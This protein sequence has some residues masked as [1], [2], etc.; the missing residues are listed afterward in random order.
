M[1]Y[2]KAPSRP[3][4]HIP[5]PLHPDPRVWHHRPSITSTSPPA[6]SAH[7]LP[8][9]SSHPSAK[10]A[11]LAA[12]AY[13]ARL[14]ALPIRALL[15][16]LPLQIPHLGPSLHFGVGPTNPDLL[17]TGHALLAPRPVLPLPRR[18]RQILGLCERDDHDDLFSSRDGR[19]KRKDGRERRV[20]KKRQSQAAA[21]RATINMLHARLRVAVG[22]NEGMDMSAGGG[23]GG[24]SGGKRKRGEYDS[25]EA[26]SRGRSRKRTGNRP[27]GM[28]GTGGD[29]EGVKVGPVSTSITL[30]PS[31]CLI[32]AGR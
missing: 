26:L 9:L 32:I 12:D 2:Y 5:G 17:S 6:R 10:V 15:N 30:H 21:A 24:G 27:W 13:P 18:T 3:S 11:P 19:P 20:R 28:V 29:K 16:P 22:G 4:A 8:D 25:W 7:P 31:M 14:C 23:S 1:D